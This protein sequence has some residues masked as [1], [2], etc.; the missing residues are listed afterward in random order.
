MIA[1]S[2]DTPSL[3][4]LKAVLLG[5]AALIEF[6]SWPEGVPMLYMY[7]IF[8]FSSPFVFIHRSC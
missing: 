4:C 8:L 6:E 1:V 2:I 5:V 7:L 3:S